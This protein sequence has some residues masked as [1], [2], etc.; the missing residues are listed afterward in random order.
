[1]PAWLAE[2]CARA[3]ASPA[4]ETR[5]AYMRRCS[6]V[7]FAVVWPV[8]PPPSTF[9]STSATPT[10][11]SASS[12]A[13]RTPVMPPP[14][15]ATSTSR[16]A[17]RRGRP[18]SR[19]VSIHND[20]PLVTERTYPAGR[21]LKPGVPDWRT[22]AQAATRPL[23]CPVDGRRARA[24]PPRSLRRVQ[25]PRRRLRAGS[26]AS[27]CR[28]A[29]RLR[30]RPRPRPR[31]GSR[32]LA[33]AV[34]GDRSACRSRA[35]H[36]DRRRTRGRRGP[37]GRARPRRRDRRRGPRDARLRDPRRVGGTHGRPR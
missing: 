36:R 37:S 24:A 31:G 16:S 26:R 19:V 34:Q 7:S 23:A 14:R 20:P 8:T 22:H 13:H 5:S 6:E 32:I 18:A 28:L 30:G 10:P 2:P 12:S 1:M 35:I 27:A 9:A 33:S 25:R 11:S 29:Q 4:L 3:L 15:T 21:R 17:S